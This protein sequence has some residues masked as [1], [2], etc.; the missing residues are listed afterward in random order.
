M[1]Q[2]QVAMK[3]SKASGPAAGAAGVSSERYSWWVVLSLLLQARAALRARASGQ[4]APP[5]Q[6]PAIALEPEKMLALAEGMMS[7]QVRASGTSPL[8]KELRILGCKFAGWSA[9]FGPWL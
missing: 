2:Q 7:R 5:G 3:L 1:K 9:R 8:G 4:P 6:V